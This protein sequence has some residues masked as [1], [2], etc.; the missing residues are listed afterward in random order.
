MADLREVLGA[1]GATD[2]VTH[3]QS[4]NAVLTSPAT[5]ADLAHDV[6]AAIEATRGI[7]TEAIV[8]SAAEMAAVVAANP[9][10]EAVAAPKT[11]HVAFLS[12]A[13][14]PAAVDAIDRPRF[15]PDEFQAH[16]AEIYVH[17]PSG[18]ADTKL[19]NDLWQ[20]AL[21]VT[22]TMRNWNTVTK[23]AELAAG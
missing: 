3:L 6:G 7:R 17:L 12:Q 1:L 20:R 9:Y 10:P 21:Q 15:Q 5:A 11:L 23:L 14:A 22:S 8:R 4:G 2:V 19:T 16:G 18:F 13:P